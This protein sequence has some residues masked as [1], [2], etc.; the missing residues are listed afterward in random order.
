VSSETDWSYCYPLARSLIEVRYV[1]FNRSR[2]EGCK[3]NCKVVMP[4]EQDNCVE[5]GRGNG[6][7]EDCITR[8]FMICT[9]DRILFR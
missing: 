6:S 9:P 8:S 7:G 3:G 5:E 4:V 1:T 2:S